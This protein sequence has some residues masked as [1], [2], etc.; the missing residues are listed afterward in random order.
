MYCLGVQANSAW[1]EKSLA[2]VLMTSLDK[3]LS[4]Q[5]KRN[6]ALTSEPAHGGQESPMARRFVVHKHWAR[7]LHYDFRL[8]LDGTLKSWAVPKGPS[9]DPHVKRMAVQVEDHPLAYASFEGTIPAKQYGAGK[10][11]IWDAG[12]WQPLGDAEAGLRDGQLQFE[13]H[14]D[15]LVGQWALIRMKGRDDKA[16]AWL[17]VKVPDARPVVG[18]Q[19][20]LPPTLSPQLATL[21]DAPPADSQGWRYEIKFDGYRL[22]TRV[23]SDGIQLLTRNGCDWTAKLG[24]LRASLAKLHLPEGWYDGEIVVINDQGVPDFGALQTAFDTNTPHAITYYLFDLPYCKGYDLRNVPLEARRAQLQELLVQAQADAHGP[25]RFSVAF[26]AAP[27]SVLSSACRM[28]LEGVIGKRAGSLYRASRSPDWIK[29]K[30]K[31]RQEFVIGGWTEP[32]GARNGL[33]SL[34]LGVHD[35]QGA[36]VYAGKVGTGLSDK[37]LKDLRAQL[38]PIAAKLSPFVHA[39][40]VVGKSHWVLP[41]LVAEVAFAEWTGANHI[42]HASFQGLR[43]D[44]EPTAITR[45]KAVSAPRA[46]R[47]AALA[48]RVS[49]TAMRV[50][51]ADR[52]IDPGTGITKGELVR[53]YALVGDLLMAHCKGR[54][55]SL[56]RAPGGV[57]G[58]QFFQKHA[59][60]E[61]LAGFRQLDVAL[62]PEHPPLLELTSQVG[63]LSAA[64]W[65]VVEF[66]T[67]NAQAKAFDRPDRMVFDLDPGEGVDWAMLQ[68]AAQAVHI[69]LTQLG[70][71]AFLKTS[72]GKGL[73][74]VVPIKPGV[75][76]VETKAFSKAIVTHLAQTLPQIFVAKSGPKNRLGRIYIDYLRNGLGAT[77]VSAWSAR[78]RPGLGI[79]VPV[80]WTELEGLTGASQWTIR[81]VEIRLDPGNQ[82]WKAYARAAKALAPAMKL[83]QFKP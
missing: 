1:V 44:K 26:D 78:A 12:T 22:L 60:T 29:L 67:M 4:Y 63:L 47:S 62:Y 46:S 75:G 72:G 23:H 53:Y 5:S 41:K 58:P 50:T 71:P 6:F 39:K 43:S 13:L 35:D 9:L 48:S 8:E 28:G 81:N 54:P 42:R 59:A 32:Q 55:V 40:G 65:N 56:V 15:K 33:G 18:V 57:G 10:V 76:W 3:L 69:F 17:L 24:A 14:G 25:V 68:H 49:S 37:A 51:N 66:H 2:L 79:S 34:L 83:L 21:V 11:I 19:A 38:D 82:P 74:I 80:D 73:H 64:Q 52:V 30:C 77:T 31:L 20:A 16:P 7:T 70:L 45:E 36:L 27:Q 61:K